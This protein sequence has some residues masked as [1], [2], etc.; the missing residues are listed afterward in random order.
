MSQ[1][2]KAQKFLRELGV[3]GWLLYDF[4]GNNPLARRFLGLTNEQMTTR[5]FF[6]WIPAV[7]E[8]VKI[9]HAIEERALD[10]A[11]GLKEIYSSWQ[12]LEA[13]LRDLLKG[14]KKVAMEYSLK[15]QIPYVSLVDAGTVDLIRSCGPIVV[16]SADFLGFFTAVLSEEE[17]QSQIRAAS[18]LQNIVFD[19][20]KWIGQRLGK[21]TEYD[22]QQKIVEEFQ[23]SHFVYDH[24]PIVAVNAN[25]ADPHYEPKKKGSS[26]IQKGD[27]LLI[28]L[29]AKEKEGIY[30]D[31]TRVAAIGE[32]PTAKQQKIFEI[33]R[34]AQKAG[35][36][37]VQKRFLEK[38]RIEGWEVDAAV[39]SCIEKE[40]FGPFFTHRTGH[41]IERELHGSGASMDNL[42]MHDVRPI[43]PGTCFSIEPGIYL[44]NEFG[45]RLEYDVVVHLD[46]STQIS[47]GEQNEIYCIT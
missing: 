15:N 1:V 46:G 25:S 33:V 24:A 6:Y 47:G 8:P 32:K 7:G 37:L 19:T 45:V 18:R 44:P 35:Y 17:I 41:N 36:S 43:L 21:I 26:L 3:D 28:D 14:V 39:R 27:W 38:K 2:E 29:W 9:V 4:H 30:G 42:E 13:H 31:L 10:G 12:S 20:W 11:S 22:A 40:G 34:L 16:S 23:K 5:R